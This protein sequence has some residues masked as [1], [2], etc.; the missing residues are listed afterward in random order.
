[1]VHNILNLL[2][3][4]LGV[5]AKS[6]YAYGVTPTPSASD[7]RLNSSHTSVSHT[8]AP[9]SSPTRPG[10]PSSSLKALGTPSPYSAIP[11]R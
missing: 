4:V 1:M 3:D 10:R 2:K 7:I 5:S 11:V 9:T 6:W 8:I